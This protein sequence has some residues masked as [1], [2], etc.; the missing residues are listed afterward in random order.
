MYGEKYRKI[1]RNVTRKDLTIWLCYV[2]VA[3]ITG[4]SSHRCFGVVLFVIT[5]SL[6]GTGSGDNRTV[7][8]YRWNETF[9]VLLLCNKG[10]FFVIHINNGP[11]LI[12]QL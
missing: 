8:I 12:V 11:I 2:I 7:H 4:S 6:T 1:G 3:E 10:L 9:I 5:L